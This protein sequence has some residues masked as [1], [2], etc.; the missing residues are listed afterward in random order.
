[1]RDLIRQLVVAAGASVLAAMYPGHWFSGL[2]LGSLMALLVV[3][4]L[5]WS[6]GLIIRSVTKGRRPDL[7]KKWQGTW[8]RM[9]K[10]SEIEG[11][12][13]DLVIYNA[14]SGIEYPDLRS[15]CCGYG[16]KM[17][18]LI[19]AQTLE[20]PCVMGILAHEIAHARGN[21]V[22]KSQAMLAGALLLG[23]PLLFMLGA[24][25][26]WPELFGSAVLYSVA[27]KAS[28]AALQRRFE[29]EADRYSENLY[30]GQM[31]QALN[32]N[33]EERAGWFDNHPSNI[34][35]IDRLA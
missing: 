7:E 17:A 15:S 14:R 12:R 5:N 26:N 8:A 29:F 20:N 16:K 28:R 19:S 6:C 22:M 27:A 25:L 3:L 13:C 32:R 35:R 34:H 24:S 4:R 2:T 21:H 31:R 18:I 23:L 10:R 9:L 1:M 11:T 30:P 33:L